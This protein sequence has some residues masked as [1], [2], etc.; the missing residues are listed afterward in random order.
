[1]KK[2]MVSA[3]TL[4]L[5]LT[6]ML[7]I[8]SNIQ[9]V[10]AE[11]TI[12]IRADGSIDQSIAPIQRYKDTYVSTDIVNDVRGILST[13]ATVEWSKTYGSLG[14]DAAY[15]VVNT[16][17]GG[18]AL[19]GVWWGGAY[20]L[21]KADSNGNM[22][23]NKTYRGPDDGARSVIQ[24]SD[25][26]Y[27]LAGYMWTD[28]WYDFG[29]I[30]TDSY[31]NMEWINAYD[32]PRK[33]PYAASDSA[34]SVVQTTDGG[35]AVAGE[36][37]PGWVPPAWSE[38]WLVKTDSYGN[39]EWNKT[40][41]GPSHDGA[42]SVVQTS[43]GGYALVGYTWP[44]YAANSEILF[45]KTDSYGNMQWNRTY[46]G[47]YMVDIAY[48][49]V[50]T[51]DGGYALAGQTVSSETF[52]Y[53]FWLIK[54]DA[55]GNAQWN[56]TYDQQFGEDIAYSIIKTSDEGYA[57]AGHCGSDLWL[58]KT[59]SYGNME[60][61]MSYGGAAGDEARSIVQTSDGGYVLAGSTWSFGAGYN[62]FWLVK[63]SPTVLVHDIATTNVTP[64]KT[65]VGQSYSMSINV[66]VENQGDYT[67][68]FNVT[69]YADTTEIETREITLTSGN[70][71]TAT[72]TWNTTGFAKG[73]YAL[74]AYAWPVPDEVDT[75]D[76]TC[77]GETVRVGIP[78][79]VD[80]VDGYVGIDD[81]FGIALRFGTE[82][83]GPPNSNGYYYSP[84]HDINGD[85]YIGIDDIF[86]AA[87]HFGQEENP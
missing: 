14:G 79:D 74:R 72:F 68:T 56:K 11:G 5:L 75:T 73:N 13:P 53:D 1:M 81:I 4:V 85:N 20:G 80:P 65:V 69:F 50:Q 21:V 60:W 42:R 49:V 87:Q 84:I 22:Q 55:N 8:A 58:V 54:T 17:D 31:G 70:S 78:G 33:D 40:Y 15:S 7:T 36:T 16:D 23:W 27:A 38:V 30:K 48:S 64:S 28:N 18:Y 45:I 41:G 63:V 67:E 76:N 3:M 71:T 62:D 43:D 37:W 77:T 24:T 52:T 35:Y 32:G 57:L 47:E 39:M 6:S 9:P 26:G 29:L 2:K 59:D 44:S 19:V 66:T 25:G 10:R 83:G 86:I 34:Y 46:S 61:N 12:Y 51:S 82:P